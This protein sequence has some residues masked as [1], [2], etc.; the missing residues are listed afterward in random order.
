EEK[1]AEER[2]RQ[3][4]APTQVAAACRSTER[5]RHSKSTSRGICVKLASP[6]AGRRSIPRCTRRRQPRPL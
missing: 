3:D 1:R 5:R 6:L 4:Q 2:N